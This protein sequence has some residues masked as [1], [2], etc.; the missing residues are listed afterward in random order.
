M[1]NADQT[2]AAL[3]LPIE[4]WL[5][6]YGPRRFEGALLFA[7][8]GAMLFSL[9]KGFAALAATDAGI[10]ALHRGLRARPSTDSAV[11]PCACPP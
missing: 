11:L 6:R 1:S 10:C 5:D 7:A 8:A 2:F 9:S 4:M 3:Q